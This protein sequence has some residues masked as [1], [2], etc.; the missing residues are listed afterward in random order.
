[1]N[2]F[3]LFKKKPPQKTAQNVTELARIIGPQLDDLSNDIFISFREI[4]ISEP[5]TFIVAAVWGT[6]KDTTLTPEQ[7]AI[8]DRVLPVITRTM[9]LLH[10]KNMDE[11]QSFAIAFIIRGLIISKITY[12]IEALKNKLMSVEEIRRDF[13]IKN[14]EPM[15]H[16]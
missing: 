15:G 1:M 13:L 12:M 14:M 11:R 8:N 3:S 6:T 7:R 2:F 16:A 9:Q 4:L 5:I 10:S